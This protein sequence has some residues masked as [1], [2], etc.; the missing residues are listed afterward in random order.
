MQGGRIIYNNRMK[1]IK[2]A[3]FIIILFISHVASASEA[4]IFDGVRFNNIC[5]GD[6]STFI[7]ASGG[8]SIILSNS[9]VI[10]DMITPQSA[11]CLFVVSIIMLYALYKYINKDTSI[12][13]CEE[14]EKKVIDIS[15]VT[16]L[17]I[18][19]IGHLIIQQCSSDDKEELTITTKEK[20]TMN[21]LTKDKYGEIL[22][23]GMRKDLLSSDTSPITF[24]VTLKKITK[25]EAL[26][27]TKVT[28]KGTIIT[29][30]LSLKAKNSA[31]ITAQ[32]QTDKVWITGKHAARVELTGNTTDQNITLKD[33]SSYKA[34]QLECNNTTISAHNASKTSI[35]AKEKLSYDISNSSRVKYTGNPEITSAKNLCATIKQITK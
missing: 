6:N 34:S 1:N 25:I 32:I 27:G 18:A 15:G 19:N 9:A 21:W 33:A 8:S 30:Q 13:P 4:I 3:F 17:S 2:V 11:C 20:S 31:L 26:N 12:Q 10:F 22:S 14:I 35:K 23:L 29:E 24:Y 28:T 7:C 16:S 5:V